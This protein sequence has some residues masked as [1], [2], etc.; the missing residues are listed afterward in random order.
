MEPI[1]ESLEALTRLSTTT[2]RNLIKNL[3]RMALRVAE[4]IP[5]CVGMS[6]CHFDADITFT[7]V[8]TSERLRML[9]AAQYLDGGPC[10][11][12]ALDGDEVSVDDLLDEGRWQLLALASAAEGVKSSLS[13]PLRHSGQL[14]GSANFYANTTHG[15]Q[16]KERDLARMFGVVAEDAVANADLS[17]TSIGRA[18]RAVERLDAYDN[19]QQAV[20]VLTVRDGV[21]VDEAQRRLEAAAHRAG[22][23]T[24]AL[25]E[26]V[27]RGRVS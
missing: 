24:A 12:A 2:D 11:V 6:V 14:Y 20:G 19:I 18:R 16:G 9:D 5:D 10:Q 1:P 13:L 23:S 4:A 22:V 8:T 25:A 17:M 21:S 3:R 27:L 26:L 7:L 15:F